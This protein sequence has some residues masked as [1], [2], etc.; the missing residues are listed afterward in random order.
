MKKK[1]K[2]AISFMLSILMAFMLSPV[3]SPGFANALDGEQ[4]A[5]V[6]EEND[7]SGGGIDEGVS[8]GGIDEGVSGGGIDESVSGGGIDEEGTTTE[9]GIG[10]T[11][12]SGIDGADD[13]NTGGA[14]DLPETTGP[15]LIEY[16][17]VSADKAVT[18]KFSTTAAIESPY[19]TWRSLTQ[20]EIDILR[21]GDEN[22]MRAGFALGNVEIWDSS[23]AALHASDVIISFDLDKMLTG[24][25]AVYPYFEYEEYD[26]EDYY[27]GSVY[28]EDD[29]DEEDYY[30]D[31]DEDGEDYYDDEDDDEDNNEDDVDESDDEDYYDEIQYL[32]EQN[33]YLI[34]D[35]LYVFDI[36]TGGYKFYDSDFDEYYYYFPDE[37]DYVF[38][39]GD[40]D[41]FYH[42]NGEYYSYYEEEDRYYN[43]DETDYFYFNSEDGKYYSKDDQYFYFYDE[44]YEYYAD[45]L[46]VYDDDD[47]SDDDTDYDEEPW[48][49]F[50]DGSYFYSYDSERYV[51]NGRYY[52]WDEEK[53]AYFIDEDYEAK[54][55]L[56][57]V[58]SGDR[59]AYYDYYYGDDED[60]EEYYYEEDEEDEDDYYTDD[61]ENFDI[62]DRE[63]SDSDD[64][65]YYEEN[66]DRYMMD[67]FWYKYNEKDQSFRFDRQFNHYD[68]YINGHYGYYDYSYGAFYFGEKGR[69]YEENDVWDRYDWIMYKATKQIHIYDNPD[70]TDGN[71][72]LHGNDDAKVFD[73][74]TQSG[75][76]WANVS[77]EKTLQY[78]KSVQDIVGEGNKDFQPYQIEY[79]GY[80]ELSQLKPA[81]EQ[82]EH[83]RIL[84]TPSGEDSPERLNVTLDDTVA[85]T[86][87]GSLSPFMLSTYYYD[88]DSPY[89]LLATEA[90]PLA[91]GSDQAAN[92]RS[93]T[94]AP[95][96]VQD[97]SSKPEQP[98]PEKL[99]GRGVFGRTGI[100]ADNEVP[101]TILEGR[102]GEQL[103]P[104][105]PFP[106]WIV[107]T[108]SAVV[109]AGIA[110]I[111]YRRR[112]KRS[113]PV[114]A[115]SVPAS[116]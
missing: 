99:H 87:S 75:I 49:E 28:D 44:S 19:V 33:A 93:R 53:D 37:G 56:P 24:A 34:N 77:V 90:M 9:G 7:V 91:A 79:W 55:G 104:S 105:A 83:F 30:D 43:E 73:I 50:G 103:F 15:A 71:L 39:L 81:L 60:D 62:D 11:T 22:P 14:I 85:N 89:G 38:S 4:M 115:E 20:E 95:K 18:V 27:D 102:Y 74:V 54:W 80:A 86:T 6:I 94:I 68:Y 25:E 110:L 12:G 10:D 116:K 100:V 64:G 88:P 8:G 2:V 72:K 111:I 51:F 58:I 35:E 66:Y 46:D 82:F 101:L 52:Y 47:D 13:T 61:D 5:S 48:Y 109:L 107:I 45:D 32:A 84:H 40:R 112:L 114:P 98:D 26:D 31:E 36:A 97:S 70:G 63:V 108:A 59:D 57:N 76:K 67:E 21:G 1:T 42:E 65:Y 69:V 113:E 96:T 106:L 16:K 92:A 23:G 29:E 17:L 78:S 3:I 41:G